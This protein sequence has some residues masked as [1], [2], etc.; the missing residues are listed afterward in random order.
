M[1]LPLHKCVSA[2][3]E[4]CFPEEGVGRGSACRI[5]GDIPVVDSCAAEA[6]CELVGHFCGSGVLDDGVVIS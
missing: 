1:V 4:F 6:V 2:A 5:A 3:G